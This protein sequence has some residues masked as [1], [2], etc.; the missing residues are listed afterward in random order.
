MEVV[1]TTRDVA[2][3]CGVTSKTVCRWY[4]KCL[5]KGYRI[6]GQWQRRIPLTELLRF[7]KEYKKS[8]DKDILENYKS[9][10]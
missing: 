5:L 10:F 9:S 8:Y 1:L 6:P 4:D 7:L 3:I 2:K